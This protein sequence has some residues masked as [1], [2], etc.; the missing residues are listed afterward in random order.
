MHSRYRP[1]N[2]FG[3]MRW[4]GAVKN[5]II[6]NG[7]V[8]LFQLIGLNQLIVQL[9]G[10]TPYA[11]THRL[12][13]WQPVTYMFVHGGFFHILF[14][15]FILWMFGTELESMWG[16]RGFLK[17][18]LI[19]G[20]GAAF[21]SLLTS[22]NSPIPTIG[23]SG[24]IYGVLLAFGLTFPDRP[25]YLYFFIPIKA[26]YLVA[27]FALVELLYTVSG[28]PNGIANAAHLGGMVAGFLYLKS[29]WRPGAWI[30]RWRRRSFRVVS[31]EKGRSGRSDREQVDRILDKILEEGVDSLTPEEKEILRRSKGEK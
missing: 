22:W 25:I 6:A 3:Y 16:E 31:G 29:D 20:L 30:R 9:F 19:C 12:A 5:L 13:V 18:Y 8:F 14:N 26:K 15:M 1:Y 10:L 7:I 21:L 2:P 17:Y 11:V 28:S 27:I 23:A 24:A 4:Q